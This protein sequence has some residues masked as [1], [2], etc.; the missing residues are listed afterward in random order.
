MRGV[1]FKAGPPGSGALDEGR[2][3]RFHGAGVGEPG[4]PF[5][6]EGSSEGDGQRRS[7]G[8]FA[9]ILGFTRGGPLV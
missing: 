2:K 6:L 7:G 3:D 1:D 8:L 5:G 9:G 4:A